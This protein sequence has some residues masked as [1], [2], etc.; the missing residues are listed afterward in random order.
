MSAALWTREFRFVA[1]FSVRD[2]HVHNQTLASQ[3]E[4][5][6]FTGDQ[7]VRQRRTELHV[8][9]VDE[10]SVIGDDSGRDH[11]IISECETMIHAAW[12]TCL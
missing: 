11:R 2:Q 4:S 9:F 12:L 3:P 8:I 7:T 10:T 5:R 1:L 6:S